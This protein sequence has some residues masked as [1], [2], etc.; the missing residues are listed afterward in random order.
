M[1]CCFS[2]YEEAAAL[3]INQVTLEDGDLIVLFEKGKTY[4]FGEARMAVVPGLCNAVLDPVEVI[5]K[6]MARLSKTPGNINNFLFPSLHSS[7][8]G[9]YVLQ[10]VASYKCV[11][12]QFKTVVKETGISSDPS[13]FGL[14][15]MRRGGVTSAINNGATDHAVQKQMRVSSMSTVRRYA[16]LNKK[17]LSTASASIF[18]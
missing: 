13:S 17:S 7:A 9:D 3:R 12:K 11:L 5:T 2:R 18:K 4:Q 10:T 8:K 14:H 15:S 1:F 16:T 6:Y